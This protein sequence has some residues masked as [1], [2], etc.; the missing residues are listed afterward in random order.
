MLQPAQVGFNDRASAFAPS[1]FSTSFRGIATEM[2]DTRSHQAAMRVCVFLRLEILAC[3]GSG[4]V[5][6]VVEG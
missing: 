1:A 4:A 2:A 6:T 5:N 3:E